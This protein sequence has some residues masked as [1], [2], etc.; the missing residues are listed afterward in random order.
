M[1]LCAEIPG[2]KNAAAGRQARK[3]AY[4]QLGDIRTRADSRK[5]RRSD[6]FADD[7]GI[8]AVIKVLKYLPDK[9]GQREDDYQADYIALRQVCTAFFHRDPSD[10]YSFTD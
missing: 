2:K 9:Y 7:D 1:I 3:K 4:Q 6:I 5:R 8:D 10:F